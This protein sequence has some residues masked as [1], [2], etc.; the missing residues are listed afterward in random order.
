M[1]PLPDLSNVGGAG[2]RQKSG[3]PESGNF[4]QI[5]LERE[6]RRGILAGIIERSRMIAQ[7][8]KL[9]EDQLGEYAEAFDEVLERIPVHRLEEC[10]RESIRERQTKGRYEAQEMLEA[11]RRIRGEERVT[12]QIQLTQESIF[13]APPLCRYCDDFGW[14]AVDQPER[15]LHRYSVRACVCDK[16]PVAE[17]KTQPLSEP[18]WEKLPSGRWKRC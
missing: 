8:S 3:M 12:A 5:G 14:Q 11:W 2:K 17:R 10:Y 9:P 4:Q 7:L 15:G 18:I 6:N 16:A 13:A 1:K